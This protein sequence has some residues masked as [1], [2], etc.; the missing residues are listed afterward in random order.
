M[1]MTGSEIL[2]R[3]LEAEGV[4]HVFGHPGGAILHTYDVMSER[5]LQHILCRHEQAASHAAEGYYKASGRVGTVMVTSGPGA[6]NTVTGLTD[7]L[8]DSM[9]M[10][11]FSGQVPTSALGC[12]A[13]QEADV[14]GTTR[15]CTKHNYLATDTAD[16][17]RIVKE[18]YHIAGSGRP[19]PVLVDLPKDI[20][21]GKAEFTGYP[22]DVSIRGYKLKMEGDRAAIR[23]A[24]ERIAR[25]KRPVIYGGGGIIHSGASAELREFV[26]LTQAP[27]TLTLMGLGAFPTADPLWLGM[28]GMHGTYTANMAMINCDLM[29]AVGSRFDDRVTGKLSE[30]GKQCEIIHIDIDPTSIRK[31]VAVDIPIVGDVAHVLRDLN[32]DLR[33]LRRSW[34]PDYSDWMSKLRSWQVEHPLRYTET[35]K[36]PPQMA[37]D[38]IFKATEEADPI[39][40]TGVGQHQMWAAQYY[41]SRKP[42]RWITSGGLGTMGFGMPAAMGA[43]VALPN[44]M[45]ILID[46]D[47]SFQMNLQELATCVEV[48]INIKMFVINNQYLG[49]VRQWQELFYDGNYSQTVLEVQPDFSKLAEA[50]GVEGFRVDDPED[51][52]DAITRAVETPGP[53]LVDIMVEREANVFPMIPAGS[54]IRDILDYGDEIPE[55]LNLKIR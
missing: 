30:F 15:M 28:P 45:V 13:F 49:M 54:P 53:V 43:Q 51:L 33:E 48:G 36:I 42:R 6:C 7:A 32:A 9:A 16:I 14:V 3:C 47:G 8:L 40:A 1:K 10:V 25:A 55:R 38:R 22:D 12:D 23:E 27:I 26:D 50:Y 29:I 5:N 20:M 24:A 34:T 35:D 4:E 41:R 44:E 17:P 31:N 37:I 19:G 39:V 21:I 52:D 46:G 2:L 18:A 11:V